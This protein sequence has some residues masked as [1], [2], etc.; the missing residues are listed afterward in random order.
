MLS[1]K[2]TGRR[3]WLALLLVP[4]C[5][6]N[7]TVGAVDGPGVDGA[8]MTAPEGGIVAPP[9]A[10][11]SLP[12]SRGC[13][14][15]APP[16]AICALSADAQLVDTAG[17]PVA[18]EPLLLCGS[19]ICSR[20]ERTDAQGRA[21]FHLCLS[22]VEPAL[23]FLGDGSYVSFAVAMT[24][25]AQTFPPVTVVPLP[26]QGSPFPNGAGSVRSGPVTLEI[27]AP[28][29]FDP[30]LPSG[31]DSVEFRAAA[32]TPLQAPPGL[33]PSFAIEAL[34]GLAPVNARLA[35]PGTLTIPNPDPLAWTAGARVDFVM[36]GLDESAKPAAPYG[37]WGVVGTGTVSAGGQ[38]ITTD[39]GLPILGL[40]GVGPHT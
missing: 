24:T 6:S 33:D 10:E 14:G 9:D 4:A 23:K 8:A 1:L 39:T 32:V 7:G 3:A 29:Q 37:G 34:W 17:A 16:G 35:P 19:N 13:P 27:I 38:T 40:V 11:A 18:G 20:P 26:A 31:P 36:N 25:P 21:H 15:S 12:C 30:T 2:R 28:P 5:S 22:M